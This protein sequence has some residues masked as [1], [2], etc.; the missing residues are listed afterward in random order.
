M[1]SREGGDDIAESLQLATS[2]EDILISVAPTLDQLYLLRVVD[3][4]SAQIVEYVTK[5]KRI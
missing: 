1:L 4:H 2:S 3:A 5:P